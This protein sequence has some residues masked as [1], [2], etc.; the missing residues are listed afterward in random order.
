[1][2]FQKAIILFSFICQIY[3]QNSTTIDLI[4]TE[5]DGVKQLMKLNEMKIQAL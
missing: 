5:I 2:I 3:S 4:N 1:M